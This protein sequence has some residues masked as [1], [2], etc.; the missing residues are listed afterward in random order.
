VRFT[1]LKAAACTVTVARKRV[2]RP[3]RVLPVPLLQGRAFQATWRVDWLQAPQ[4]DTRG[5][6]GR[7]PTALPHWQQGQ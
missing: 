1:Y 2:V 7:S 5:R 3:W 4:V 6:A